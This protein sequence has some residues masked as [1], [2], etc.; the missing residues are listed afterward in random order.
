M[1]NHFS[2]HSLGVCKYD[3]EPWDNTV[4]RSILLAYPKLPLIS[5]GLVKLRKGLKAGLLME[6]LISGIKKSFENK[7]TKTALRH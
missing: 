1:F 4:M 2:E 6:G 7:Q 5:P 3:Q